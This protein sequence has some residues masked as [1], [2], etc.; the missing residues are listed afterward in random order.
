M[1]ETP[2]GLEEPRERFDFDCVIDRT[3]TDSLKFDKAKSFGKAEGL[4]S[5]WVADMDFAAPPAVMRAMHE[6]TDHGI[7]GYTDAGS[8]Y[9][10]AV[11]NWVAR[12]GWKPKP[13]WIVSTPGVVFALAL[14]VRTFTEP[15][16]AVLIQRPVYYPFSNVVEQSGRRLVN[17]PLS[18]EGTHYFIDFEAVER[19]IVEN[20]V[21]L[22]LLC[23]PHNPVGRLWSEAELRQLAAICLRHNVL[24]VSDEIHLDFVRPGFTHTV[25]ASLGEE[26]E[27]NCIIC[28]AASKTFNLAGL[29][30]SNIFIPNDDL[31]HRYEREKAAL[32]VHRSN[33]M[34]LAAT[35]AC[36]EHGAE[37]LEQLKDYLEGNWQ[38]VADELQN[39][40]PRLRLVPAESTY[41][42]WIDCRELGLYGEDLRAFVEDEA[43]LWL[44][45]GDMFGPEGD[46]C[47]RVNLATQ[48]ATVQRALDGLARAYDAHCPGDGA[49]A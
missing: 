20:D 13:E 23:N 12:Y 19:A 1:Q 3:G 21:K 46:G 2:R 45:L 38:L 26:V 7:F 22:F 16:D 41:L 9:N 49:G 36:Y 27:Q 18:C 8:D 14:A 47:I 34:G 5:M 43:G 40:M 28:T 25:F 30:T 42:A 39:R 11:V 4:L 15:G 33:I 32:G 37:W 29:Q 44:D 31:R 17:V 6:R 24:V 48:R 10:E 35:R